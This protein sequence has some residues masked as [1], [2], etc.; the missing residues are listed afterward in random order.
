M[1][2][3]LLEKIRYKLLLS[4]IKPEMIAY[5]NS[6]NQLIKDSRISNLTHISHKENIVIGENVFIGHFN[7][8]DGYNKLIIQKGCQITNYVSIL[9]HSSHNA[10]RLLGSFYNQASEELIKKAVKTGPVEI[11]EYTFIGA[12]SLIMP[13]T[14][15]GKGC[16]VSAYSF[17]QGE[18]P[19]YSV[20]KGI[21]A[22]IVGNTKTIDKSLQEIIKDTIPY[23][24]ET[25]TLNN[26]QLKNPLNL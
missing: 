9:T 10:I 24:Y 2:S 16:I 7:Y 12:H 15:I 13:G 20:I 5:K 11:G 25:N 14:K 17:I 23:Y 3:K 22:T 19:D 6:K 1:F 21:P 4:H 26:P 18:F 8:L